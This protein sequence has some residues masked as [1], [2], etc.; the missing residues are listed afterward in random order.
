MTEDS[1]TDQATKPGFNS[2]DWFENLPPSQKLVAMMGAISVLGSAEVQ[3]EM[4][5]GYEDHLTG[6][7][8]KRGFIRDYER[9]VKEHPNPE[10]LALAAIDLDGLKRLND[11]LGHDGGDRYLKF[12][13]NFLNDHLRRRDEVLARNIAGRIGGDEFWALVDLSPRKEEEVPTNLEVRK[14]GFE[15]WLRDDFEQAIQSESSLKNAGGFS[16]GFAS[17]E[18]SKSVED[19]MKIADAD[20]YRQ[21]QARGN[22]RV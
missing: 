21:K 10:N 12:F 18:D 9:A 17:Y 4:N 3:R 8:N 13:A 1:T 2:Q 14:V 7:P 16:I 5:E 15:A 20:M 11:T 6:L 19:L 22:G